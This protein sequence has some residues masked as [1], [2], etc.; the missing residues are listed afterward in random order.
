[1]SD[2]EQ[3]RVSADMQAMMAYDAGKKSPVVAYLLWFFLASFGAHRFYLGQKGTA[4][5]QL[6]LLI[7]GCATLVVLIGGVLLFALGIWVLVDAFL[8][9]GM[10][11]KQNEA[12]AA[13]LGTKAF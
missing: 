2:T 6:V 8:I 11:R 7:A 1:M 10:I 5:A 13:K 4:I 3:T 12:L 9:P